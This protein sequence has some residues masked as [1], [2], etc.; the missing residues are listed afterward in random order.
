M[1]VRAS[2]KLNDSGRQYNLQTCQYGLFQETD[3]ETGQPTS[4]VRSYFISAVLAD[5]DTENKDELLAWGAASDQE[6]EGEVILYQ[7]GTD[8]PFKKI[9]FRGGILTNLT[10]RLQDSRGRSNME[11]A[12]AIATREIT[13]GENNFFHLNDW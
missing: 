11:V 4:G 9:K 13:I 2:L 3:P 1:I 7:S 6:K 10:E 8:A 12:L 5:R